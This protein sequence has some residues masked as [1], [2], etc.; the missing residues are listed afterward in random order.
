ML[1]KK[2]ACGGRLSLLYFNFVLYS[3]NYLCMTL[4]NVVKKFHLRRSFVA[5]LFNFLKNFIN[6][7]CATVTDVVK[8]SPAV[9]FSR[10]SIS[11]S[12]VIPFFVGVQTVTN[13]AK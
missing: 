5:L 4:T 10:S 3:I 13:A 8:I 9:G 12:F 11:I 7:L 6:Y 2:F 1:L